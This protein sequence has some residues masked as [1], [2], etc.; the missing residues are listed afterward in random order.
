MDSEF[1]IKQMNQGEMMKIEEF[2]IIN[3]II[4][5]NNIGKNVTQQWISRRINKVADKYA[6]KAS[7]QIIE[8]EII[9]TGNK[10]YCWRS[11][12][13]NL[14]ALGQKANETRPEIE[15]IFF[16]NSNQ[17]NW[18]ELKKINKELSGERL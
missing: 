9:N 16:E 18:E 1:V 3:S 6:K 8:K 13:I 12:P 17:L 11:V 7:N 15:Q 4:K 2:E 10:I 5:E 14:D